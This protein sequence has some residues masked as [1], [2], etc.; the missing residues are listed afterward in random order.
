MRLRGWPTVASISVTG[1][2]AVSVRITAVLVLGVAFA[3]RVSG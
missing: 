2:S 1:Q 3:S